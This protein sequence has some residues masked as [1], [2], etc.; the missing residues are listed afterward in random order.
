MQIQLGMR[1]LLALT[2][3]TLGAGCGTTHDSA[4]AGTTDPNF[5]YR[6][7]HMTQ[8]PPPPPPDPSLY[9]RSTESGPS[10]GAGNR[11]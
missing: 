3:L 5:Q 4:V 10:G 2:A 1:I 7:T 9:V 8:A 11:H 6:A